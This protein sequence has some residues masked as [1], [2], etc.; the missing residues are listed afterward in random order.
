MTHHDERHDDGESQRPL[1]ERDKGG[2]PPAPADDSGKTGS[3]DAPQDATRDREL[4]P[5]TDEGSR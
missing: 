1:T 4:P 2:A 5:G 3:G